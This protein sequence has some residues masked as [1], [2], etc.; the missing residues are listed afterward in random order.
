MKQKVLVS[1]CLLGEKC[2]Y[3]G[4]G[5][6]NSFVLDYIKDM[7][8]Y[9]ICPEVMGGL[10]VPR[11]SCEIVNEKVMNKNGEDMTK[12]FKQGANKVVKLAKSEAI[13]LAILKSRSPSCGCGMIYDG[14]FSKK[15]I[16]GDGIC[17]KQLKANNIEVIGSDQ[18]EK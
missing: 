6:A 16:Q 2:R 18:L 4:N 5:E 11:I 13:E 14:T 12:Y 10:S 7:C 15:L 17:V 1:A 3:D 9:P 8:V